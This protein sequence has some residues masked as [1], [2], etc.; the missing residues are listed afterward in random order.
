MR[1]RVVTSPGPALAA[2]VLIAVM[3]CDNGRAP[4]HRRRDPHALVVAQAADVL[5]L[6]PVRVTDSESIEVGEL[7]FEGLVRWKPGTTDLEPGLATSWQAS[8]DGRVWTFQLREGVVFHDGTPLDAAAVAFSFERLLE[9]THPS[10][11]AGEDAAYW[12]SQMRDVTRV[13]PVAARTVEI[14][15]ARPYAPLLRNLAMF[16]IVSP[17]A[18]SRWG[19]AFKLHPVG[20]GPFSFESWKP[21][22]SVVVRRFARYWG[23][24]P[25]LATIVFRVVVDARQR[26]VELESGSVD[27][28]T[29]ILPDEQSF[30]E[31]HPE[32]ELHHTPGN[33]VSYLAFNLKRAPFDQREIR[34]A[35]S[36]AINK[37]PIVKLAFQ[38]RAIAADGPLPPTQWGYHR[39]A[40]RY[41]FDPVQAR[42]LLDGAIAAHAFDPAVT[43]KLYAPTTPRPYMPSPERVARFLQAALAQVGMRTE[44]V[45]QPYAQHRASL[46]AGE[47]DLALFGWIGDTGDPDNFLYVLFHSANSTEGAANNIAFYRE[48]VVDELL[49]EAQAASDEPTR[50]AL[51]HAA[52]DRIA[53]DAPWVPIAHSEYVVAARKELE[54]V[55]LS[56]LGH[57]V[58]S[59]IKRQEAP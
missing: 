10:Y 46:E 24:A 3:A 48:P 17:V 58:Y 30:V 1:G 45:L 21:G 2:V 4:L 28:A 12:R 20:T 31:L 6:D 52:V 9:P 23:A 25:L 42:G 36:Y 5:A 14:H 39:P 49:V 38:G 44:L 29:A 37:E 19:D 56:P 34:R 15:V 57:P 51:Y 32:L 7:L 41:G 11:L 18:A 40:I 53:A 54:G 47:H 8:P 13:V 26:L 59:R 16:P 33:D 55:V 27:L 35:A 43:Y 50:A 22:D